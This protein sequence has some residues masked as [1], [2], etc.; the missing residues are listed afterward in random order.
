MEALVVAFCACFCST[1]WPLVSDCPGLWPPV[2]DPGKP[3][4]IRILGAAVL[5][6]LWCG[7]SVTGRELLLKEFLKAFS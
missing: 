1:A 6:L 7:N 2:P 5:W 4:G 3:F